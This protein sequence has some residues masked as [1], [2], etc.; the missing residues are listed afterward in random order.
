MRSALPSAVSRRGEAVQP[1]GFLLLI[2]VPPV[3]FRKRVRKPSQ[4]VLCLCRACVYPIRGFFS[5]HGAKQGRT[6]RSHLHHRSVGFIE[7]LVGQ[8]QLFSRKAAVEYLTAAFLT[9]VIGAE[10]FVG[11]NGKIMQ[12]VGLP[13]VIRAVAKNDPAFLLI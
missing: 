10:R 8:F 11:R 9:A 3:D 5:P 13:F 4:T 7:S 2:F 6:R 1:L 12:R